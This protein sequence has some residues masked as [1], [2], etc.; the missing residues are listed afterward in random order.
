[1]DVTCINYVFE[2]IRE[3]DKERDR[4]RTSG[5][6]ESWRQKKYYYSNLAVI[7]ERVFFFLGF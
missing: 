6:M 2:G 7:H 4:K 5:L 1:M 3:C